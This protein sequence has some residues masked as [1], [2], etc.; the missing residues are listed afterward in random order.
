MTK[1]L[2]CTQA[3]L[4]RIIKAAEREG[5]SILEIKPDGTIA[6][7]KEGEIQKQSLASEREAVL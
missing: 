3:Q 7:C 6:V 1:R 2:T 5:Y 4:R